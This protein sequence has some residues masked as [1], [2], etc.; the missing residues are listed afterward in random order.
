LVRVP[1]GGKIHDCHDDDDVLIIFF[2]IIFLV[3]DDVDEEVHM[4]ASS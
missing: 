1:F 3:V 2:I 4:E